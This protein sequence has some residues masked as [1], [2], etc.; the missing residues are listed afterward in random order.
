M[1]VVVGSTNETK[2]DAVKEVLL[3]Y[4]FANPEV[5]GVPV[6]IEIFGHPK[7]LKKIVKG[8]MD[9]ARQAFQDCD[10][11]VGIEGGLMNVPYTQTGHMEVAVCAFYDGKR[12]FLGLSPAFEW[13]KEVVNLIR[14][15]LD[16]SQALKEAGITNHHK[17]GTKEGG[18]GIFTKGN[19]N[20]KEY[21]KNAV[22]MALIQIVNPSYYDK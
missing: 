14:N 17:I 21:N 9:R 6:T 15:G 16:G 8:A 12:F 10:Y 5:I 4:G 3:T 2:I 11:S 20:R 7:T 1:R 19:M 22:A 18:I 13:P